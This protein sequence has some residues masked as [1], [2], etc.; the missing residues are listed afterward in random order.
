MDLTDGVPGQAF[1][2]LSVGPVGGLVVVA[3]RGPAKQHQRTRAPQRL[4]AVSEPYRRWAEECARF[5]VPDAFT[6]SDD[7]F[8]SWREW[9]IARGIEPGTVKRLSRNLTAMNAGDRKQDSKT[10]RR[11]FVGVTIVHPG[12]AVLDV[13]LP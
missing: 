12:D 7:L 6:A 10:R 13:A 2:C 3:W 5:G 9:A 1:M 8:Q 11:G 4:T